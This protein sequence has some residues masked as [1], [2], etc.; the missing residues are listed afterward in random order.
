MSLHLVERVAGRALALATARQ[1]D[2]P[3]S[4]DAA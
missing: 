4:P 2:M 1:L 3:W